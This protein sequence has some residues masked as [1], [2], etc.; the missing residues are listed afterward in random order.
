MIHDRKKSAKRKD[1]R[2]IEKESRYKQIFLPE[3]EYAHVM[4]ELNTHMSEEDRKKKIVVKPIGDYNYIVVIRGFDDYIITDK[5]PIDI[6][7]PD[8]IDNWN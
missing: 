3:D 1:N 2:R 6:G 8:Y 7:Y 5:I 4:S